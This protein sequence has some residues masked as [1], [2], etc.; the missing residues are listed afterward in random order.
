[1]MVFPYVALTRFLL[2]MLI[3]VQVIEPVQ[4]DQGTRTVIWGQDGEHF[5]TSQGQHVV[6][7]PTHQAVH[8][9]NADGT[10][11]PAAYVPEY[12]SSMIH[13]GNQH[14]GPF[15]INTLMAPPTI[16]QVRKYSCT[17]YL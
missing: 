2:S 3:Q 12:Q 15:S 17:W 4:T 13:T 7:Y 1:M 16:F 5:Q 14:A 8:I 6:G 9:L 11:A 10:T